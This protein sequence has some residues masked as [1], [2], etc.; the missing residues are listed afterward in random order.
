VHDYKRHFASAIVPRRRAFV[1]ARRP[2]AA[3]SRAL[4][5]SLAPLWTRLGLLDGGEERAAAG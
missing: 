2:R 4:R 5:F 1:F 3:L